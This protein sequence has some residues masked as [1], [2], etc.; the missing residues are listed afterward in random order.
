MTDFALQREEKLAKIKNSL[1]GLET[2]ANESMSTGQD[3]FGQ[4]FV[5]TDLA[6]TIINKVRD[7]DT[8][9]SKLPAPMAMTSASYTIPVEGTDPT[10]IATA[11]NANVTGT[12][13]TTSKAGTEDITLVA[14]KY[15]TSVYSSG[16]LDDDSIINI[17]NYLGEKLSKSYSELLD[18]VIM[19]GDTVTA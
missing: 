4:D 1:A 11:E 19:H 9:M 16:E 3:G 12:A 2:R 8:L 14:K 10:W 17:R 6:S 5:P 13:V 15:S 18:K 7:M